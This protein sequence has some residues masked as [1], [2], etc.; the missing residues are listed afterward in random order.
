MEN[1]LFKRGAGYEYTEVTKELTENG[2][3][4]TKKGYKTIEL[5]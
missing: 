2:I 1:A 3:K 5:Y 4:I